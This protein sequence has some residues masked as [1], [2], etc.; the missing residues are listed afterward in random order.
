[1]NWKDSDEV[2]AKIRVALAK[3]KELKDAGQ[4]TEGWWNSVV[5]SYMEANA[6]GISRDEIER[7]MAG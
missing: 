3:K 4:F 5:K 1:M 7:L 6:S 2:Y